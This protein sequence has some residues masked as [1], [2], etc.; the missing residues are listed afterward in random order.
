MPGRLDDW[1]ALLEH[2]LLCSRTT[3]GML[4]VALDA[5]TDVVQLARV[6]AAEQECCSFF[7]F[8][9]TIDQRGIALEVGAPEGADEFVTAL[10]DQPD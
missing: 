5:A 2:A 1:S 7:S 9:I 3:D 4:R 8:A 10:F 6:V